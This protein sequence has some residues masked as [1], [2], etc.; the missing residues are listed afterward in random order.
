M[1]RCSSGGAHR[2]SA[3]KAAARASEAVLAG[4][5][6]S[7]QNETAALRKAPATETCVLIP[8]ADGAIHENRV[9]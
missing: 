7:L 5:S 1:R 4:V 8:L 9:R 2:S 6:R 3:S